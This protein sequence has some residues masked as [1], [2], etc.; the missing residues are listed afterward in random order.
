MPKFDDEP[1]WITAASRV[2]EGAIRQ[3]SDHLH[4]LVIVLGVSTPPQSV[5]LKRLKMRINSAT[6]I[7]LGLEAS[8]VLKDIPSCDRGNEVRDIIMTISDQVEGDILL[9]DGL[10]VLLDPDLEFD[11]IRFLR[12]LSRSRTV[13]ASIGGEY[14]NGVITYSEQGHSEYRRLDVGDAVVV[15]LGRFDL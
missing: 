13:V 7:N 2:V 1:N 6:Y 15:D 8:K 3:S 4:R 12:D 5:F 9:F 11:P 10:D 14:V